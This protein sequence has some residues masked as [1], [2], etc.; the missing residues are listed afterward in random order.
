LTG[1]FRK[2]KKEFDNR[3]KTIKKK[4]EWLAK[5]KI[6]MNHK[7]NDRIQSNITDISALSFGF[8]LMQLFV[9]QNIS[10]YSLK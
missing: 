8:S 9:S 6:K 5:I 4:I 7:N 3:S 2:S 1:L 10:I